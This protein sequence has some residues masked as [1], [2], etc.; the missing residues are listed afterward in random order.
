MRKANP[1]MN[2]VERASSS[3]EAKE[4]AYL[5]AV[6]I[7]RM[8]HYDPFVVISGEVLSSRLGITEAN[9]ARF[10]YIEIY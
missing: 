4:D 2:T 3:S 10:G 8:V 6:A 7:D 1:M 9:M 5:L